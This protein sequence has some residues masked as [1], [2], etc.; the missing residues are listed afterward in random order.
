MY[1]T[2][3]NHRYK[4]SKIGGVNYNFH[5]PNTLNPIPPD[6]VINDWKADYS[7]MKDDMIYEKKPPSFE[8][9]IKNLSALRN[10]LQNCTWEFELDF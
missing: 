2:I 3:V 10:E 7:K 6:E 8:D 5:N 4:F 1:E 9:L